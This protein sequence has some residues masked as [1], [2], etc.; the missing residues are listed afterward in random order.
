MYL[1][2]NLQQY[3][4]HRRSS[5]FISPVSFQRNFIVSVFVFVSKIVPLNLVVQMRKVTER[6]DT[7]SHEDSKNMVAS[8]KQKMLTYFTKSVTQTKDYL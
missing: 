7:V 8:L 2:Q 5:S 6:L 3:H 1:F 4:Q